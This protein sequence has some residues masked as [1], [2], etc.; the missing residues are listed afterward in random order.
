[1]RA[2][3]TW[4]VRL[5]A[6]YPTVEVRATDV[7]RTVDETLMVAGLVRALAR[8]ALREHA[9]GRPLPIRHLS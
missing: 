4:D 5:S 6:R 8:V 3:S 1:M 9:S 7:C 2:R